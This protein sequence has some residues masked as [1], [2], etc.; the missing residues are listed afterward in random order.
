MDEPQG[1]TAAWLRK[2]GPFETLSERTFAQ[3]VSPS[4]QATTGIRPCIHRKSHQATRPPSSRKRK[5]A[6]LDGPLSPRH[7][8]WRPQRQGP[9]PIASRVKLPS[10][11]LREENE[12]A[13]K[14]HFKRAGGDQQPLRPSFLY[15]LTRI[16]ILGADEELGRKKPA[17][18]EAQNGKAEKI[19]LTASRLS[20]E[21]S[22]STDSQ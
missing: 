4:P 6:S 14:N 11:S 18:G 21:M 8:L 1:L 12:R 13:W 7:R 20:T 16:R 9:A 5:Q 10:T 2:L 3:C 19:Y 15:C 17:G 22:S